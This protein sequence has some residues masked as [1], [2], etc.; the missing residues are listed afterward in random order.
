[1]ILWDI[2]GGDLTGVFHNCSN[3]SGTLTINTNCTSFSNF[4]ANATTAEGADL[5]VTG[6]SEHL[7]E[8]IATKSETSNIHR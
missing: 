4:F 3:L 6:K 8:I 5:T 7:D 2:I 1:M